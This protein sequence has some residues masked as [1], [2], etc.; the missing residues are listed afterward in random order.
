MKLA[1]H[2]Q[3]VHD[4]GP[5]TA[6]LC[7]GAS[8][9]DAESLLTAVQRAGQQ[10]EAHEHTHP[11]EQGECISPARAFSHLSQP[12]LWAAAAASS[13]SLPAVTV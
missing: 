9:G 4:L 10:A 11:E 3:A 5:N 2:V 8:F 6:L 13:S 12:E 1:L 7:A